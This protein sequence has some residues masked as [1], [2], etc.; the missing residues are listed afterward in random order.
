MNAGTNLAL[1]R[2]RLARRTP[3]I[4]V[5]SALVAAMV[6]GLWAAPSAAEP[7]KMPKGTWKVLVSPKARWTL[8]EVDRTGAKGKKL[9]RIVVETYDVRKVGVADVARL[10]WT[11]V[12]GKEK[13]DLGRSDSGC[14]TQVAV[15]DAGLYLLD[16]AQD[17]AA[18]AEALKQKP[19]RSDP[20][21]PYAGTM[22]NEGRYLKIYDTPHG[23]IACLGSGPLP[24]A[25]D[26]DDVCYGEVCISPTAGVV[27]L[28]GQWAPN[29][30]LFA[31]AGFVETR[32]R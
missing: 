26:C 15:T 6:L 14:Y 31:Q 4:A 10:R 19:S 23:P 9:D 2:G 7:P 30:D 8:V 21:K 25:G 17:D 12:S 24:D 27:Q 32:R 28:G 22:R 5:S 29:Y 11:L 16:A 18:V 13:S 1:T 3:A 20:P